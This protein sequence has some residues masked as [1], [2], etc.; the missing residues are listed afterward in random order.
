MAPQKTAKNITKMKKFL[1]FK[2]QWAEFEKD[3]EAILNE[4]M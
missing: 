1:H 2:R 3:F 4:I